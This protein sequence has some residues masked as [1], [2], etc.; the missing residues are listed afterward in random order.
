VD[1]A[2]FAADQM[3]SHSIRICQVLHIADDLVIC[4]LTCSMQV[5]QF[6]DAISVFCSDGSSCMCGSCSELN[7][8]A[9]LGVGEG[10]IISIHYHFSHVLYMRAR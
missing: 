4:F 9:T 2:F 6:H 3:L 1:C 5:F 8:R 7:L 10:V